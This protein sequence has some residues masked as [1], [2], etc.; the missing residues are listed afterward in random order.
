MYMKFIEHEN[1]PCILLKRECDTTVG[2]IIGIKDFKDFILFLAKKE[3]EN[4]E[5]FHMRV[6]RK[7]PNGNFIFFVEDEQR[8]LNETWAL[9]PDDEFVSLTPPIYTYNLL[10]GK[11]EQMLPTNNGKYTSWGD[12][13]RPTGLN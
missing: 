7:I 6:E 11:E 2:Y 13:I 1:Q 4:W 8:E 12:Y 9:C 5:P 3:E 10:D